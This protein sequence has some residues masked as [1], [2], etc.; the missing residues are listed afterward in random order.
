MVSEKP[1][2][3]KVK[4]EYFGKFQHTIPPSKSRFTAQEERQRLN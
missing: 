3:R 1:I 2:D 4:E